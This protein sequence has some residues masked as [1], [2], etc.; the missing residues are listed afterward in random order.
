[1]PLHGLG[2]WKMSQAREPVK[3][4]IEQGYRLIDCAAVYK[5]E[6]EVGKGL[7]DAFGSGLCKREDLFIV[8]KLW[9]TCHAPEHVAPALDSTLKNL[10]VE[11]L[12]LYLIHWPVSFEFTG[13][14]DL[15]VAPFANRDENGLI[16]F[17]K[18]PLYQTWKAMEDLLATG[19][20]RAIG[21]SNYNMQTL[22]DLLTYAN[23]IPHVLQLECHPYNTRHELIAYAKSKGMHIMSYS[24]LGSGKEGPLQD[25]KVLEIATKH[26]KSSAQ[27]LL[28]WATQMGYTVMPKS[29]HAE[30]V[31]ENGPAE[32]FSFTLDKDE[33]SAI[34]A[35]DRKHMVCDMREYWKFPIDV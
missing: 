2:T 8:S 32:L 7:A 5:N 27:V 16:K 15:A 29:S 18:A 10:G 34:S 12:D 22:L 35:L 30:R 28:R 25:A 24:T 3:A 9:N 13:S 20:V 14:V 26:K 1:M 17:G 33:V 31:K 11:Y 23:V 19:K 21:I 4:A 6:I